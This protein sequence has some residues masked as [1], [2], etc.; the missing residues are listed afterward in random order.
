MTQSNNDSIREQLEEFALHLKSGNTKGK[1]R[2]GT[3]DT[4]ELAKLVI[5][6]ISD[7]KKEAYDGG[8]K[9]GHKIGY[10][11]GITGYKPD[12]ATLKEQ[13]SKGEQQ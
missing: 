5:Q 2:I 3:F 6:L 8:Y 1:H 12:T 10:E 9:H 7:A 11:E 13:S 4:V